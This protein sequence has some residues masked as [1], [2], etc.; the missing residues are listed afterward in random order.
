MSCS[1]ITYA[2]GTA[3]RSTGGLLAFALRHPTL[4]DPTGYRL[5]V[6][7]RLGGTAARRTGQRLVQL[8]FARSLED[9]GDLGE[10]V[11]TA[12]RELA[13]L[14]HRGGLLVAGERALLGAVAGLPC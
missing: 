4:R 2:A 1:G 5:Q 11:G 8:A 14:G 13:E 7:L 12:A 10:Q 9:P 6:G 3:G